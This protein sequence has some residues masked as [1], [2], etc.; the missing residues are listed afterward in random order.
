M[1]GGK[2]QQKNRRDS[3]KDWRFHVLP[4][5]RLP[6]QF[7]TSVNLVGSFGWFTGKPEVIP[8]DRFAPLLPDYR[9][10]A[11]P[12]RVAKARPQGYRP[13]CRILRTRGHRGLCYLRALLSCAV[14]HPGRRWLFEDLPLI[15][16]AVHNISDVLSSVMAWLAV[17][18]G[19]RKSTLN[20]TFGFRRIEILAA[21]LNSLI[22]VVISAFLVFEAISRF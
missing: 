9:A 1:S 14:A 15:S 18:S 17:R 5:E 19:S 6:R 22:L 20:K 10:V 7:T 21:F 11:D 16:D 13:P 4:P 8:A 12:L 3:I 2:E